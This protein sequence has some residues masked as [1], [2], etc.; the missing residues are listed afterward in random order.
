MTDIGTISH[1]TLRTEDLLEAFSDELDFRVKKAAPHPGARNPDHDK[2][3]GEARDWLEA[4]EP[5]E[6]E[7]YQVRKGSEA[8][9]GRN[10]KIYL[11]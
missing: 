4:N 1:G 8:V 9:D 2:L 10:A 3:I 7:G 11:P 6:E 5:D